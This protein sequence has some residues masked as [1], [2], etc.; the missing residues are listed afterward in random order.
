V[1][2]LSAAHHTLLSALNDPRGDV[3]KA[4]AKTLGYLNF[5]DAQSALFAKANGQ[6][7]PDDVQVALFKGLAAN[8]KFYGNHLDPG[9][10]EALQK[11]VAEEQALEVKSAAAEARGALNLPADQAKALIVDQSKK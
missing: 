8:A 3:V 6:D 7:T 10:I 5:N 11:E 4:V 1:Y 2:D 9:Q